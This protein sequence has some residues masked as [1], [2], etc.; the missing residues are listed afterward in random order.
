MTEHAAEVEKIT[1]AAAEIENLQ[2]RRA[3]EPKILH[4]LDVHVDPVRC[5]FVSIDLSGIGPVGI[6]LAQPF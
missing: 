5:V 1:G 3:I 6:T 2:R 4:T